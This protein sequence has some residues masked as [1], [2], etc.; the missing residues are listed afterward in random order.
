MHRKRLSKTGSR[1]HRVGIAER[2]PVAG[3]RAGPHPLHAQGRCQRP[4]ARLPDHVQNI[5]QAVGLRDPPI[6]HAM[7]FA[8]ADEHRCPRCRN[9]QPVAP[10]SPAIVADHRHI[11]ASLECAACHDQ[12]APLQI[13][14]GLDQW[15]PDPRCDRTGSAHF[16]Q[17]MRTAPLRP[18]PIEPFKQCGHIRYPR[19]CQRAKRRGE[20]AFPDQVRAVHRSDASLVGIVRKRLHRQECNPMQNYIASVFNDC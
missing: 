3:D 10:H 5:P 8:I 12:I 19:L 15:Q 14:K 16:V 9:A 4:E 2:K 13:G 18:E 1:L 7:H 11:I 20:S 6:D 17:R